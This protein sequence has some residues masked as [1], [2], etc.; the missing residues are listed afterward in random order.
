MF[1]GVIVLLTGILLAGCVPQAVRPQPPQVELVQ[2]GLIGIDPFSGQAQFDV[3]LRLS[4]PNS[5][6][7]PL[8]DS[9]I[10]AELGGS[11][12]KLVI[13]ALEIPSGNSR[14]AATRLVVPIVEGTRALAALVSG[15]NTRFR[16]LGELQARIGPL[17]VPVGPFTLVDRDVRVD[18]SFRLP[19]LRLVDIR[20]DGLSIRFG[21]EVDNPNLIGFTLEGPLK[22]K[23]GGREVAASA[24]N[25][26]VGPNAKNRGE[27]A[28][29]LT[30]L[31][32]LG[33][34]SVET[35]FVAR[36]PGIFERNVAQILQGILR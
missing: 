13:P 1:R 35:N 18:F 31:P 11:A 30:G 25:L 29:Q 24:F 8:L 28:L 5:Y 23:I 10:T 19:T 15:Q 12:F 7:L 4:N 6:S 9:T 21:L 20:L 26:G 14:E 17:T 34:L 27:L 33:G 36:I 32:G 3:R 22:L 2:F 16:L